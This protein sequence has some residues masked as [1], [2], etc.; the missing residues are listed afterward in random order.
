M[1]K[2]A[3]AIIVLFLVF[4][5]KD[6]FAYSYIGPTGWVFN[7]QQNTTSGGGILNDVTFTTNTNAIVCTAFN[8]TIHSAFSVTNGNTYG[9]IDYGGSAGGS[10]TGN[11]I[12]DGDWLVFQQ[13]TGVGC[14]IPGPT[15]YGIFTLSGGGLLLPPNTNTRIDVFTYSTTTQTTNIQGY[16]NATSTSLFDR[17]TFWQSST[18][19]GQEN[20]NFLDATTS[21]NFN[22]TY[23]INI[24]TSTSTG[25]TTQ[26][27]GVDY[28]LYAYI[29]S[30]DNANYTITEIASSSINIV[31][32]STILNLEDILNYP[33]YEC[34]ITSITGC[35]KNALVWAFYPTASSLKSYDTFLDLIKTKAPI[36]YFYV[37]K[38]SLTGLNASSTPTFNIT[39]PEHLKTTFFNPIDLAISSILWIYYIVF[40]YKRI[41]HLQI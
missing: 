8:G 1:K 40:L 31:A 41:K 15:T 27:I 33:E 2:Y 11:N 36:G 18:L 38:D 7:D 5:Y 30:I 25:T 39:I 17:L 22:V 21:G 26:P 24:Y 16:F 35:V 23:P 4:F 6:S 28:T 12:S 34:S 13:T 3:Y 29:Q 14:V 20:Y 10:V 32:S 37:V 9:I 19:V